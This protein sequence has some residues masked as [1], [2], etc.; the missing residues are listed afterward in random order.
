MTF[1]GHSLEEVRKAIVATVVSVAGLVGL[2]V[3][4]DPSITEAAVAVVIA[5]FNVLA[6]FNAP[7]TSYSDISKT[8]LALVASGVALVGFFHTFDP[9]Q[10]DKILAIAA[11]LVNVGGVFYVQNKRGGS[12]VIQS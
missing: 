4:F 11:A 8:L 12:P 9:G 10:T 6:V 5:L 7:R 1:L 3:V 2:F